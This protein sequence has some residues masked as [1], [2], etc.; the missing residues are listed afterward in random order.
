MISGRNINNLRYADDII[1]MAESKKELKS[2]L[3]KVKERNENVVLKISIQKLKNVALGFI[4]S[5][6]IEGEKVEAVTDFIFLGSKITRGFPGG[7]DGKASVYKAG[8]LGSS[9]GLGRSPG[10]GNGNPLQ[11]SCLENSMVGEP[12]GLRSMGLQRVRHD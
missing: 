3:M 10:E 1:L 5:W 12:R 4:T 11:Y 2:L 7:S 8:D 6:Q 9:P